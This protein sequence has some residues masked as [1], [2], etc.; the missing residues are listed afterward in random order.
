MTVIPW[1]EREAKSVKDPQKGEKS[2]IKKVYSES[3]GTWADISS[4]V[5]S[6]PLHLARTMNQRAP[7]STPQ[8]PPQPIRDPSKGVLAPPERGAAPG[9][10]SLPSLAEGQVPG[11]PQALGGLKGERGGGLAWKLVAA[12]VRAVGVGLGVKAALAGAWA[13]PTRRRRLGR[14]PLRSRASPAAP[15]EAGYWRRPGNGR[16]RSGLGRRSDVLL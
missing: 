9:G 12:E 13:P 4:R 8:S 2:Y 14:C 7:P 11:R 3:T 1:R 5:Y 10:G 16:V 15:G 6:L